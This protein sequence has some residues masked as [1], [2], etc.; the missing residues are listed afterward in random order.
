LGDGNR[1]LAEQGQGNVGFAA[2]M[3][4]VVAQDM[5][6][7]QKVDL[8]LGFHFTGEVKVFRND[9]PGSPIPGTAYCFGV[10]GVCPCGNLNDGSNGDAGCANGVNAGGAR[11]AGVGFAML[12]ND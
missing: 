1:A 3:Y 6:G 7:D 5:T 9:T 12:S 11:L 8:V 10:L 2:G 4:A